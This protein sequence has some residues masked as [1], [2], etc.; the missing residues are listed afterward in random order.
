MNLNFKFFKNK[1][2]IL[3]FLIFILFIFIAYLV[4]ISG[5]KLKEG[6]L[7]DIY[8]TEI[9]PCEKGIPSVSILEKDANYTVYDIVQLFYLLHKDISCVNYQIQNLK[10]TDSDNSKYATKLETKLRSITDNTFKLVKTSFDKIPTSIVYS[11]TDKQNVD[12]LYDAIKEI[13]VELNAE[14]QEFNDLL[15]NYTNTKYLE[16]L[17]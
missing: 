11:N 16:S 10:K 14:L 3:L 7:P 4:K 6:L 12:S 1:R 9:N 17:P 5:F 2:I 8:N 13:I 15:S